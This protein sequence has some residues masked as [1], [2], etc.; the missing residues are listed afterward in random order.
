MNESI[1]PCPGCGRALEEE[2]VKCPSCEREDAA[3]WKT[4][5]GAAV[6]ILAT[7]GGIVLTVI[8]KGKAKV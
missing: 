8:T 7:V 1:R 4:L 5:V 2:E 3:W 6:P